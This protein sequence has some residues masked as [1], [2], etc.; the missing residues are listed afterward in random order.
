MKRPQTVHGFTTIHRAYATHDYRWSD[1]DD[2]D[3]GIGRI[4]Q[5]GMGVES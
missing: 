3:I 1:F 2:G 4:G 5:P